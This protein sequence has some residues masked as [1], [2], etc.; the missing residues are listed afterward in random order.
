VYVA[1]PARERG[2]G[3]RLTAS[4]AALADERGFHKMIG[5][6]FAE[7]TASIRLVIERCGF[8][9]VGVHRRYGQLD[10]AGSMCSSSSCW[11]T[12]VRGKPK[13]TTLF[14]SRGG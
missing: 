7:N 4:L 5:R 13:R 6:L 2:I 8:R 11:W 3:T 12:A 14:R 9:R 10:G 1:A